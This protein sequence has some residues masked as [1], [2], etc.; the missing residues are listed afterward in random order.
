MPQR[1]SIHCKKIFV[2]RISMFSLGELVVGKSR[3]ITCLIMKQ[4]IM[5]ICDYNGDLTVGKSRIILVKKITLV[6]SLL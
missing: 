5:K 6:G 3:V 1:R 4:K 2:T